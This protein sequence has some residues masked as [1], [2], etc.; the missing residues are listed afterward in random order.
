M[1]DKTFIQRVRKINY[2]NHE[3]NNDPILDID[4]INV[5]RNGVLNYYAAL[6]LLNR[7]SES[8]L[9]SI[10]GGSA[11]GIGINNTAAF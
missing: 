9:K 2:D 4:Q 6:K 11:D 10:I 8:K 5:N 3:N 1:N 7:N